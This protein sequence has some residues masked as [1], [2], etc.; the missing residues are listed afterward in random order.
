MKIAI[1]FSSEEGN[2]SG[3]INT[4]KGNMNLLRLKIYVFS[5]SCIY[6]VYYAQ[7]RK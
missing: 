5:R 2:K 3:K 7:H 6:C 1:Y 4:S